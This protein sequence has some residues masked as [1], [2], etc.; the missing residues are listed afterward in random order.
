MTRPENYYLKRVSR[1][2]EQVREGESIDLSS[3]TDETLAGMRSV[4]NLYLEHLWMRIGDTAF[5]KLN[6]RNATDYLFEQL[7]I[8]T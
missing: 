7:E 6:Y 3:V 2:V 4:F 5:N 8:N 1:F